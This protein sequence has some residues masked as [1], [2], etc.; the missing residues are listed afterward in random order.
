MTE[1]EW[2]QS[3]DPRAM[4]EFLKSKGSDRKVRLFACGICRRI[5]DVLPDSETQKAL[6]VAESYADD[7]TRTRELTVARQKINYLYRQVP[8]PAY[9]AVYVTCE[10]EVDL[11]RVIREEIFVLTEQRQ[12]TD[13][14]HRMTAL[15][16]SREEEYPII[17]A[18]LRHI[19]GN[20][21]RPAYVEPVWLTSTVVSV[22]QAIYEERAFDRMPILADALEDSGCANQEIL[23]HC[24][25]SGPHIRG[26]WLVDLLLGKE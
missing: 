13:A 14:S 15:T 17:A 24:R 2:L 6:E 5:W 1:Q 20:P 10:P 9:V 12:R 25:G 16:K 7:P 19:V 3:T 8:S 23:S 26:C 11:V 22:A 18:L 21:F 4:L